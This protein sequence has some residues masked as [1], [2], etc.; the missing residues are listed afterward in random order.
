M[1]THDTL[2]GWQD[3]PMEKPRPTDFYG[4]AIYPDEIILHMPNGDKIHAGDLKQYV[5]EMEEQ[6]LMELLMVRE[7]RVDG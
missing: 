5:E 7:E 3:L 6:E 2:G 4:V 1:R